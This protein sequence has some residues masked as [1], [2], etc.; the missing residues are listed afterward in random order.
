MGD[1]QVTP[2][3][4]H[5]DCE[6]KF[7]LFP[8]S[9]TMADSFSARKRKRPA[10]LD[11]FFGSSAGE[12]PVSKKKTAVNS[13]SGQYC[14]LCSNIT[15]STAIVWDLLAPAGASK[16]TLSKVLNALFT[17]EQLP[18]GK[19]FE[20]PE[21][22]DGCL[23]KVCKDLVSDLDRLQHET[24][25]VRKSIIDVFKKAKTNNKKN[26]GKTAMFEQKQL[27]QKDKDESN[28]ILIKS[29]GRDK[30][31][32]KAIEKYNKSVLNTS[33][34]NPMA[35]ISVKVDDVKPKRN[36]KVAI[37]D[38]EGHKYLV[39]WENYPESEDTW[40]LRSAVPAEL[41]R[42]YE[43]SGE[44]LN[45]SIERQSSTAKSNAVNLKIS[46]KAK[47][48]K[49][50]KSS[51]KK[52]EDPKKQKKQGIPLEKVNDYLDNNKTRRKRKESIIDKEEHRYLVR[53][54]NFP[55]D[56]D[57]WELRSS[58]PEEIIKKYE[59]GLEIDNTCVKEQNIIRKTLRKK[60][61]VNAN[62]IKTEKRKI[63]S[64]YS[65]TNQKVLDN[66]EDKMSEDEFVVEKIIKKRF[67]M[68]G[69]VEYLV[70]WEGYDE[71]NENTWEPAK[72]IEKHIVNDFEKSLKK[73]GNKTKK[74]VETED[75]FVVERIL[76]RRTSRRGE[77]EFLVKWEGYDELED[78][79]WE[80]FSNMEKHMVDAFELEEA[81]VKKK[82]IE[83]ENSGKKDRAVRFSSLEVTEVEKQTKTSRKKVKESAEEKGILDL[84]KT[85]EKR[86]T[87]KGKK[88]YLK[89]L[90]L[91]EK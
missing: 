22:S 50:E 72:N 26:I 81:N 4:L 73:I 83:N 6:P 5:G 65:S 35:E 48:A 9:F 76:E 16:N 27:K 56:K 29:N 52:K 46:K 51:P 1:T 38:K 10:Y 2:N 30:S 75:E 79:T 31:F 21:F 44:I 32:K 85:I 63:K 55:E 18:R 61:V 41:I 14:E 20:K 74:K 67:D 57:T 89:G 54:E 8:D 69:K 13:E 15:E 87:R 80:P 28:E 37:L 47:E 34:S 68:E 70:K 17:E 40:E 77:V 42:K 11:E 43:D 45:K 7:V 86:P 23:C 33:R 78:N 90:Q 84:V 39:R 58:I 3:L 62:S 88:D 53:W 64:K 82:I 60:D 59:K 66:D 25:G 91:A 12:V 24:L 71:S 19:G 49:C 36:R